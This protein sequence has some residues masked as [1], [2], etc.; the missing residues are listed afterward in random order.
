MSLFKDA[1]DCLAH[2]ELCCQW[3]PWLSE[4][5]GTKGRKAWTNKLRD[6]ANPSDYLLENGASLN[7]LNISVMT[8]YSIITGLEDDHFTHY[9]RLLRKLNLY[10]RTFKLKDDKS[11]QDKIINLEGVYFLSTMSELTLAYQANR[12]YRVSFETPFKLL[13]TTPGKRD[14]DLSVH[15]DKGNTFHLEVYMPNKLLEVDDPDEFESD[16]F[17]L[18]VFGLKQDDYDFE[19]RIKSKLSKKFG[20]AGFSGLTGRVFLAINNVYVDMLQIRDKLAPGTSD[21]RALLRHLPEGVDG[22]VIFKDSFES[23][24]SFVIDCI[25]RKSPT[26]PLPTPVPA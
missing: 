17:P 3:F 8:G 16:D 22:L 26:R 6:Q 21:Y 23:D 5:I 7:L 14:I 13:A 15:T 18:R 9:R 25:L 24:D 4:L 20:Q 11:F 10:L 12:K 2:L 1:D 19:A